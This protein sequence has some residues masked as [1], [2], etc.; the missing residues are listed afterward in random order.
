MSRY[1]EMILLLKTVANWSAR[2][3]LDSLEGSTAS[4]LERSA[5]RKTCHIFLELLAFS[6]TRLLKSFALS[7]LTNE[8][9][10]AICLQSLAC[11]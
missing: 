2:P 8:L 9:H 1:G 4:G 5:E 7:L 11:L 6:L 3:F 10:Q